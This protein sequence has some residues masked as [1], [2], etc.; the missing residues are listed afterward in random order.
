MTI[1]VEGVK[2]NHADWELYSGARHKSKVLYKHCITDSFLLEYLLNYSSAIRL[3]SVT[4]C[5]RD[6]VRLENYK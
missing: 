4:S 1:N 6:F 3:Y 2:N 5:V